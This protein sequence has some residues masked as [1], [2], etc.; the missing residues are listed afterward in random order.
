M[1]PF[2][3]RSCK[4]SYQSAIAIIALSCTIFELFDVEEYHDLKSLVQSCEFMRDLYTSLTLQT[5]DCSMGL[6][7]FTSTHRVPEK[8][9]HGK[10][11]RCGLSRSFIVIEMVSIQSTYA[12]SF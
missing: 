9:I 5:G 11:V 8:A 12:T 6:S 4:T 3:P 7:S 10:V 2:D 1:T